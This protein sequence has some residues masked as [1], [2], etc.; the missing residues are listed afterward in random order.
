MC[1]CGGYVCVRACVHVATVHVFEAQ[2]CL[3]VV[4]TA[5]GGPDRC[6]VAPQGHQS[7]VLGD[8]IAVPGPPTE[9]L[10][11]T[12]VAGTYPV[13]GVCVGMCICMC[14]YMCIAH[15]HT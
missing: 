10:A 13:L 1:V 15:M 11:S 5:V 7:V 14:T 6:D 12:G 4:C 2:L 9:L 3:N 8:V